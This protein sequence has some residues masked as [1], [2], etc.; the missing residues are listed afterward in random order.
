VTSAF[1]ASHKDPHYAQQAQKWNDVII[2]KTQA[3]SSAQ[4]NFQQA[5]ILASLVWDSD[6]DLAFLKVQLSLG[7][8]T[9]SSITRDQ[10]SAPD[11]S[12]VAL[13]I[14][15]LVQLVRKQLSN[16]P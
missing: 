7:Q 4:L 1:D 2:A 12:K 15:E 13:E 10:A 5:R 3:M 16:A 14:N 9:M 8:I 6:I 11:S